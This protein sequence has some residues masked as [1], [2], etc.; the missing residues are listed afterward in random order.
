ML[1]RPRNEVYAD[2][3]VD[4]VHS[5]RVPAR[6]PGHVARHGEAAVPQVLLLIRRA[7]GREG[8]DGALPGLPPLTRSD[9]IAELAAT[10]RTCA[11]QMPN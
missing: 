1:S 5:W 11:R 9:L 2:T 7:S 4:E 3:T 8:G 6:G 10:I